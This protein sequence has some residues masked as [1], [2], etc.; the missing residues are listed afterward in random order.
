MPEV[1]RHHADDGIKVII[2]PYLLADDIRIRA[3]APL[4]RAVA[5]DGDCSD[6]CHAVL[7]AKH[8]SHRRV[9]SQH[10]KI[11]SGI[12]HYFYA[13]RLFAAGEVGVDGQKA[14]N[15]LEDLGLLPEITEFWHG[16]SPVM[17]I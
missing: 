9:H 10:G 17:L 13:R 4:P 8:A 11:A 15:V 14:R 7:R 12:E 2:D 1:G 6:S 3:E 16:Q 5:Q